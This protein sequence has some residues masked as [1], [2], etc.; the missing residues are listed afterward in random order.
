M[1][2]SLRGSDINLYHGLCCLQLLVLVWGHRL[3][4]KGVDS[5][6]L[7]GE[8]LVHDPAWVEVAHVNV[9]VSRVE[10]WRGSSA[11][12]IGCCRVHQCAWCTSVQMR[13]RVRVRVCV[14]VCVRVRV[15]A[16]WTPSPLSWRRQHS[17]AG[18]APHV[19]PPRGMCSLRA[20]LEGTRPTRVEQRQA[21]HPAASRWV[22]IA[23]RGRLRFLSDHTRTDGRTHVPVSCQESLADEG[24]T[25]NDRFER[26]PTLTRGGVDHLRMPPGDGRWGC[27]ECVYWDVLLLYYT[28]VVGSGDVTGAW[29]P[30]YFWV[31]L[32]LWVQLWPYH[33]GGID[34]RAT[35]ARADPRPGPCVPVRRCRL[36]QPSTQPHPPT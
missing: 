27:H 16:E 1:Q 19:V 14:C 10:G 4:R 30:V 29:K 20:V 32:I 12:A 3:L 17:T 6:E 31:Q 8:H 22:G 26:R 2:T 7:C 36:W 25:H 33:I 11:R 18:T 35:T 24:L 15:R 13:V 21:A 28:P 34:S 23:M 9:S 5:L